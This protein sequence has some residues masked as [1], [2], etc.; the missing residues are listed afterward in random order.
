MEN[1]IIQLIIRIT[2][3]PNLLNDISTI[4]LTQ[5][6]KQVTRRDELNSRHLTI[7][8]DDVAIKFGKC[9]EKTFN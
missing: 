7:I 4:K 5:D 9:Y 3:R 2:S 1:V 8:R 6:C